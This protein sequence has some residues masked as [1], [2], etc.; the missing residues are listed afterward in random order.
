MQ[1]VIAASAEAVLIPEEVV[2][3][4]EEVLVR[5]AVVAPAARVAGPWRR[6]VPLILVLLAMAFHVACAFTLMPT[7]G[8][9]YDLAAL[10]GASEAWLKWGFP[11]LYNWK[12]GFDLSLLGVGAQGLRFLL[13]QFGMS[14][15]AALATAWKVPLVLSDLLVGGALL[16]LGFL[17]RLRRPAVIP[18]LWLLS[19]VSLWVSA[20]HGQVESLTVLSFALSLDLLLRR[21]PMLAGIVVGL[22][23]GI[24][25]LPAGV[26]IAV[27]L[28]AY[29]AVIRRKE[30]VRFLIG[31]ALATEV[32]FLPASL[33]TVGGASLSSGLGFTV[34]VTTGSS[35]GSAGPVAAGSSL[36]S[37]FGISPGEVW[38]LVLILAGAVLLVTIA[39]KSRRTTDMI[40]RQRLGMV[41]AGGLLL[42][43]VLLDPGALPQFADLALGALCLIALGVDLS[44][45]AIIVGPILQLATGLLFVSGGDFQSFWYDMWVKTGNAG[46]PFPDSLSGADA[47]ALAG[48]AV[49]LGGLVLATLQWAAPVVRR[50]RI[51]MLPVA[52][53]V[54]VCGCAFLA[55]WSAQPAYWQGVGS[56]GPSTLA[57]FPILTATRAG[58]VSTAEQK[59]TVN[60]TSTLKTS[61]IES[62]VPP[63][64]LLGAQARP[65]Y[66]STHAGV[67][68][69]GN[70]ALETVTIPNWSTQ[71]ADVDSVWV[72]LLVGRSTWVSAVNA[73]NGRP[74]LSFGSQEIDPSITQW[75][76]PG[77]CLIAYDVPATQISSTGQLAIVLKDGYGGDR[78]DGLLIW[79]GTSTRRWVL[80]D[81]HQGEASVTINGTAR[82]RAV[83]LAP[84]AP[85]S[86]SEELGSITGLAPTSKITI[87]SVALGGQPAKV[88]SGALVWPTSTRLDRTFPAPVLI[89]LGALDLVVLVGGALAVGIYIERRRPVLE[90]TAAA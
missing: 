45:I 84:P 75:L 88:V 63:T 86:Y 11:L 16:D 47:A 59:Q 85:G 6:R 56:R 71:K 90:G 52:I 67:T 22:G 28:L 55:I 21:H 2:F 61:A 27:A 66:S 44:P 36:W 68:V 89:G 83:T 25:F 1:P 43:V 76:V 60:F 79:N 69:P 77:W 51:P 42:C 10:T 30:V 23:I 57:D 32:C 7:A 73:R 33:S 18:V 64:L 72:S 19:P 65:L 20:G 39:L 5:P 62:V 81:L 15:A 24:E 80:V 34:G 48:A 74:V 31:L 54:G 70:N 14:G 17:L 9:P 8:Q 49:I 58:A 87:S 26:L 12:F 37:I 38:L 78:G 50:V 46:W 3:A 41:A 53:A 40:E 4:P 13:E 82:R 29:M 35:K